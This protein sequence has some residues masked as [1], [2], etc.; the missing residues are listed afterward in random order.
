MAGVPGRLPERPKII[1][2]WLHL[3]SGAFEEW[4]EFQVEIA[5]LMDRVLF[6]EKSPFMA[7]GI[8]WYIVGR[9]GCRTTRSANR[10]ARQIVRC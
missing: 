7:T 1:I 8:I 5:G 4:L 2:E 10:Q 3:W 6:T 9:F